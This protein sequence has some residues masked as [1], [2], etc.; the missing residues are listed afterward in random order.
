M[1]ET[2]V[3]EYWAP[4]RTVINWLEMPNDGSQEIARRTMTFAPIRPRVFSL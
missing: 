4:N 2:E 3:L 1:S